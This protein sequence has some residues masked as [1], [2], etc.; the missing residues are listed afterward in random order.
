[1]VLVICALCVF[2][3]ILANAGMIVLL[4]IT[5][6]RKKPKRDSGAAP[7]FTGVEYAATLKDAG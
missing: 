3:G 1:M 7:A 6:R 2:G 5:S 4:L